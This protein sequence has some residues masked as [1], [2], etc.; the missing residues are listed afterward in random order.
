MSNIWKTKG[1]GEENKKHI[2][3]YRSA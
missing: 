3:R 1:S 2:K